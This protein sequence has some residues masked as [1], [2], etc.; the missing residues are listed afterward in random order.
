MRRGRCH[1]ANGNGRNCQSQDQS[2]KNP[3]FSRKCRANE[4]AN[5]LTAG[6]QP[7]LVATSS[8]RRVS[9]ADGGDSDAE[10]FFKSFYFFKFNNYQNCFGVFRPRKKK[11]EKR[12]E[13]M[14]TQ[15]TQRERREKTSPRRRASEEQEREDSFHR[16]KRFGAARRR[17]RARRRRASVVLLLFRFISLCSP[18]IS[19]DPMM[20]C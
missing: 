6:S 9:R 17:R 14:K 12:K 4:L 5:H 15:E 18:S 2:L 1:S 7:C 20:M 11:A 8:V 10:W 3:S 16:N 19:I 13:T